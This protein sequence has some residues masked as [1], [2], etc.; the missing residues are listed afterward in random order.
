MHNLDLFG[1]IL[2]ALISKTNASK[3]KQKNNLNI[4]SCIT[5]GPIDTST[6]EVQI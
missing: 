6:L 2:P 3:K 1:M 5:I 4:V